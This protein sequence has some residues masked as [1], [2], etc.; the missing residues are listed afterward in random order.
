MSS[1]M[2]RRK[3]YTRMMLKNSLIKLLKE[4]PISSLTVKEICE[5]ADINRSTFYSHYTD[6]FDLLSHIEDDVLND[7]QETLGVYNFNKE[8]EALQMT[9]KMLE[10]I[11][12]NQEVCQ[13]LLSENVNA[14]FQNKVM[15]FAQQFILSG[16]ED[17]E[18]HDQ[19]VSEYMTVFVVS[20]T[21]HIIKKWLRNGMDQSPQQLATII[22]RMTNK[23]LF[24]YYK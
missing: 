21:I 20:G 6:Q 9:V 12:E 22:N 16:L 10:Y 2:D 4:K 13:T 19:Q 3:K 18:K 14:D 8:E 23:G 11:V 17:M 7:M 24:N 5:L 15:N 1:K